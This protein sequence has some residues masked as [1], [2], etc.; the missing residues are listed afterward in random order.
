MEVPS[1]DAGSPPLPWT[2]PRAVPGSLQGPHRSGA[3]EVCGLTFC[4]TGSALY[5][6]FREDYRHGN[7]QVPATG[8]GETHLRSSPN[9][10]ECV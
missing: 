1:P 9:P 3:R 5:F 8:G 2:R 7:V 4:P 6:C 10:F